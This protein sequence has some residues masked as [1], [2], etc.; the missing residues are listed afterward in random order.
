MTRVVANAVLILVAMLLASTSPVWQIPLRVPRDSTT[1]L[2]RQLS[3]GDTRSPASPAPIEW[4]REIYATAC[5]ACHGSG[6]TDLGIGEA[7]YRPLGDYTPRDVFQLVTWGRP[8]TLPAE[9][10][11]SGKPIR[12]RKEHP[13]FPAALTETERWA[14]AKYVYSGALVAPEGPA[15]MALVNAAAEGGGVGIFGRYCAVCHGIMGYGNGPLATDLIPH[16]RDLRD[17]AWLANQSNSYL[18]AT[19]QHG[20]SQ[21]D[22]ST[23]PSW[24]GMP[25]FDGVLDAAQIQRLVDYI[26]SWGYD[27]EMPGPRPSLGLSRAETAD[28]TEPA[29]SI[30]PDLNRW[31]WYEIRTLLR[32][33]PEEAPGWMSGT[34]NR[35][36]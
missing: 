24:S 14:V 7:E 1:T 12:L 32:D 4:G 34:D 27:F 29:A 22:A 2:E 30:A 11:Y 9:L 17:T 6:R 35:A 19:I 15:G 20:K 18:I 31:Q 28:G 21:T 16:P 26:F 23:G 8:I 10:P 33:A 5:A 36:Q 25:P 13:A 3:I